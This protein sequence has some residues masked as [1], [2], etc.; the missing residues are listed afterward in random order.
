MLASVLVLYC[1]VLVAVELGLRGQ[2]R[3]SRLGSG[4]RRTAVPARLGRLA[5]PAV[6]G[7]A[8]LVVLALGVPLA[9]IVRWLLVGTSTAFPAAELASATANAAGLGLA[10]ALATVVLA[11]PVAWLAVRHPGRIGS[12]LERSTYTANA[13]PGIVVAL[14][15]VTVSLKVLPAVY[16]TT[17]LL[18]TAY[19]IMFL[20][21]ATVAVR[22]AIAQAP[23][24]LD[25]VAQA[26]GIRPVQAWWRVR[27]PLIA[28]GVGAGA[29][30]VF[31]AV[32]TELTATLLLSPTGTHTL[33]TE[34]WSNARDIDY[35][36]AAP[37][38]GLMVLL[39]APA[40][41]LLTRTYRRGL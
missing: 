34:F 22:A 5:L 26:L 33:A 16:Q 25:D 23:P 4:A 30:L 2:R 3:Y 19:A 12:L 18:V 17:T 11:L 38:A 21:R 39:S 6:A 7:L 9:S 20:P 32:V 36:A 1:G 35:G 14:A 28:P 29:V 40:T 31:L 41:F 15:L 8:A 10:G 27:L 13:L 37:Y 24:V